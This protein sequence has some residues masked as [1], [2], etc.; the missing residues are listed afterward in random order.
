MAIRDKYFTGTSVSRYLPPGEHSWDEAVY[1]SGKPVLDAELNLSQEVGRQLRSLVQQRTVPSGWLRGPVAPTFQEGMGFLPTSNPNFHANSLWMGKRTALVAGAPIV[2]EYA[3]TALP[4]Q[5]RIDLSAATV[6][7]GTGPSIKRTDFVFL[8]VWRCLVSHSPRASATVE[9]VTWADMVAGDQVV[10]NGLALT[11]TAGAPGLNEFNL[12][13]N[14]NDAAANMRDAI[15]D[16]VNGFAGTCTAQV[17][18]SN[19]AEV[20]LRVVDALAG[21]AGNAVTLSLVL[22]NAGCMTVNG[23]AGPTTFAGGADTPNKPTQ[24]SLYRHGNV[25]SPVSTNLAD[26]IAD[27]TI[28]TETAARVQWQ[29]RIRA[30]GVSDAINFKTQQ[31]G[32]SNPN[33]LAQGTQAAGVALYPFVKAD[34][35]SVIDN[36]S[37]VAYDIRDPG[38][39]VAGD[40]SSTAAADLGTVDGYVYAIPI[41][42]VFRRNDAYDGAALGMVGFDPL[43]NTNGALPYTHPVFVNPV[44]GTIE[45]DESDRP[46]GFFHDVIVYTDFL[47][48]RKNTYPAGLDLKAE[49]ERQMN[50]L[51]DNSLG[52]W[53]IDSGDKSGAMGGGSGDVSWKYMVCNEVGR[54]DAEGGHPTESGDT[55]RGNFIANFDHVRRRF[56]DQPVVEYRVIPVSPTFTTITQPGHFVVK[57]DA[58]SQPNGWGENDVIH[59]DLGDLNATGDGTWDEATATYHGGTGGHVSNFFP[60]GTMITGIK[61][62]RHDDGLSSAATSQEVQIKTVTGLGTDYIQI[63]LDPNPTSADGGGNP[64]RDPAHVQ[65]V[66][67]LGSATDDGSPRRIFVELEVAY[68]VGV[69]TSDT[70]WLDINDDSV[71]PD[72]PTSVGVYEYGPAIETGPVTERP[73]DW[74]EQLPPL[75]RPSHR[76]VNW[77][78]A[79]NN[80]AAASAYTDVLV[81]ADPA[82]V[83]VPRRMYGSKNTEVTVSDLIAGTPCNPDNGNTTYGSSLRR[84]VLDTT[85]PAPSVPFTNAG[86]TLCQVSWFPQD[87]LP[88]SGAAYG[89][90]LAVYYRTMA[91]QTAGS[92]AG[93]TSLPEDIT[94]EPLVMSRDLWTNT[95]SVGSVDVPFPYL[96]PSDQIPVNNDTPAAD[97]PGEWVLQATADISVMDF[98]ADVGLLNLHQMV[99]VDGTQEFTFR[100][101]DMDTEFRSHYKVSDTGSYRPTAMTQPL[102]GVSTHKVSFPFLARV[103]SGLDGVPGATMWRENEVLLLVVTRYA[104]LDENN[105]IRFTETDNRTCVGVYRTQGMTILA[106]E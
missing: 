89:Y 42:F 33:V 71:I 12:G 80:G 68:P 38:L 18:V 56:A 63:T 76:E 55:N 35:T 98:D 78:Y 69:G 22:T 91:E 8:E 17:D 64:A 59:I 39:W 32:F 87:P 52:T 103:K 90:Q 65:M 96:N 6:Y 93:L 106:S 100:M 101:P 51:L 25:Q 13:A 58:V 44:I 10:I 83:Y 57:A 50:R 72:A 34:M 85:G 97:F 92:K 94:V 88:N 46:D 60:S 29:Y 86:S 102:S 95:V 36:S 9:V 21:A 40:G 28:G 27:P 81:S 7:D 53:A 104:V 75:F 16:P 15:L 62:I 30:S 47:D 66:A 43:D 73:P 20:D 54:S 2:V 24:A 61:T 37:A 19:P 77:E 3:N 45:A 99:A 105:T 79:C 5:N 11:A 49:L 84:V 70:P 14:A 31:D 74:Q 67:N 23:F 82:T 4:D 1:Q 26:R 41:G 48:L